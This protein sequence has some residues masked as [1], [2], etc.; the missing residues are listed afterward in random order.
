M[1]N[2][3]YG[4]LLTYF[5]MYCTS[6]SCIFLKNIYFFSASVVGVAPDRLMSCSLYLYTHTL[7]FPFCVHEISYH[8]LTKLASKK[9]F[10]CI[11]M[12]PGKYK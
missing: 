11:L 6:R 7:N 10:Y 8:K 4:E 5:I 9:R 3:I 1:R 2:L 12:S